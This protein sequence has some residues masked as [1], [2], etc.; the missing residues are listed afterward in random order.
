[1]LSWKTDGTKLYQS[2]PNEM[3]EHWKVC[4]PLREIPPG[5]P[6]QPSSY[7]PW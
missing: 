3:F 4:D 2:L 6:V 7:K 5:R 1:M